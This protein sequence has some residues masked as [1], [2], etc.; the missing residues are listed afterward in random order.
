MCNSENETAC[1]SFALETVSTDAKVEGHTGIQAR[2]QIIIKL[3]LLLNIR[4]KYPANVRTVEHG[5]EEKL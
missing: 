2:T 5:H 4:S 1:D 3:K